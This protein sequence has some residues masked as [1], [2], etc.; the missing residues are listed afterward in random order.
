[1]VLWLE[2]LYPV[3]GMGIVGSHKELKNTFRPKYHNF[4]NTG[5]K[6]I[7]LIPTSEIHGFVLVY[8]PFLG[9]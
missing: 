7:F 1:M 6:K 3:E 8:W 2:W 5:E 4:K 9:G